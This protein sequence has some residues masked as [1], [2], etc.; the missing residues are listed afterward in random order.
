MNVFSKQLKTLLH[1]ECKR[2]NECRHSLRQCMY[3]GHQWFSTISKISNSNPRMVVKCIL[4]FR[5]HFFYHR[6]YIF[7]LHTNV[8]FGFV[9]Y[10]MSMKCVLD[11]I[12][13][14]NGI[15]KINICLVHTKTGIDGILTISFIVFIC[16][17]FRSTSRILQHIKNNSSRI[18]IFS[19]F[20]FNSDF[21]DFPFELTVN[22]FRITGK[23]F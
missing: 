4:Y 20:T 16:L 17:L 22:V 11:N 12:Y 5:C 21:N 7:C 6:M 10:S 3:A 1:C 14:L 2:I 15:T 9:F 19:K 8:C 23:T 18:T 13:W